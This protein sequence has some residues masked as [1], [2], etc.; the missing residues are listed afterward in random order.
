MGNDAAASDK[1]DSISQPSAHRSFAVEAYVGRRTTGWPFARF[2]VAPARLR[3]RLPFP[4]FVSRPAA[5]TAIRAVAVSRTW[6]GIC[7]VRFEDTG[8][9]L[10]DAHVHLPCC[11]GRVID[12]LLRCG[13]QVIDRRQARD[14]PHPEVLSALARLGRREMLAF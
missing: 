14:V 6:S 11:A 9:D 2:D 12:H 5:Q 1:G 7:C 13:Y 10:A 4:W 8:Q 3:V